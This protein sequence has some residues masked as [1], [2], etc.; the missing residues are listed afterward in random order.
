MECVQ[1]SEASHTSQKATC[2]QLSERRIHNLSTCSKMFPVSLLIK[3]LIILAL[4]SRSRSR[5]AQTTK[6]E[7]HH[8][9]LTIEFYLETTIHILILK[10][11]PWVHLVESWK[12]RTS[13]GGN[14]CLL[15]F[16][17][18]VLFGHTTISV[19]LSLSSSFSLFKYEYESTVTFFFSKCW[20]FKEVSEYLD[21]H[22]STFLNAATLQYS[23]SCCADPWP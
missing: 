4:I 7:V 5:F 23:S 20:Y 21:Q 19:C 11:S 22:F 6:V 2:V 10:F 1:A 13:H 9:M 16:C 15:L 12:G 3:F 14:F 8:Y 17:L 18:L